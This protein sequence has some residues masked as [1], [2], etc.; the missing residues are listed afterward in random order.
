M[1]S[2]MNYILWSYHRVFLLN[3]IVK[4]RVPKLSFAIFVF[5]TSHL[6]GGS[7]K[8]ALG[9]SVLKLVSQM[10]KQLRKFCHPGGS[11]LG[12]P[13]CTRAI[14]RPCPL[15]PIYFKFFECKADNFCLSNGITSNSKVFAHQA[16]KVC[17]GINRS[18]KIQDTPKN[19][20]KE[21][22]A[23]WRLRKN[24]RRVL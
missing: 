1:F 22:H 15:S 6:A 16:L 5:N 23:R 2:I 9:R 14:A 3:T 18:E 13:M 24:L 8:R 19:A 12:S 10:M 11:A 17:S 7:R 21:S 4:E 20:H